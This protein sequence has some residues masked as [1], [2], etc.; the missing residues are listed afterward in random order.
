MTLTAAALN[1]CHTVYC[2]FEEDLFL[3]TLRYVGKFLVYGVSCLAFFRARWTTASSHI[4][5]I[6]APQCEQNMTN[7]SYTTIL[8]IH[9]LHWYYQHDIKITRSNQEKVPRNYD[10]RGSAFYEYATRSTLLWNVDP[11]NLGTPALRITA[12]Q[13]Q[14]TLPSNFST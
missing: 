8:N 2:K 7:K 13:D 11:D 3:T 14:V 9:W 10:T 4:V 12:Q 6:V 5:Q 1:L